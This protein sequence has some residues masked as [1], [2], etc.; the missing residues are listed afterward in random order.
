MNALALSVLIVGLASQDQAS[1]AGKT[2]S[3]GRL[4]FMKTS[5]AAYNVRRGPGRGESFRLQPEPIFRMNN[6]IGDAVDG[7]IF[8]WTEDGRPMAAVQIFQLTNGIWL[9]EFVSLATAPLV[10]TT[11]AGPA[12]SP[13]RAGVEFRPIPDAPRPADTAEQ[14]LRQMRALAQDFAAED[15]FEGRNWHKLRLLPRPLARYG[16]T[17]SEVLDGALFSLVMGTDPEVFL[18]FEARSG[19][20]GPE[21]QYAFA[22][23]TSYEVKGSCKGQHVWSL[24]WRKGQAVTDP[25]EPWFM[26]VDQPEK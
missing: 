12:W 17:G 16:R 3:A 21:W 10:A 9:Q 23:M 26:I 24:P 25:D 6:P 13:R 14:R 7:A 1:D 20:S 4:A 2:E 5:V 8:F 18:L 19:A 11:A 22:P 15:H